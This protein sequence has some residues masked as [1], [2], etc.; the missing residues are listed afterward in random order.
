MELRKQEEIKFHNQREIDR[1]NLTEDAYEKKYSNKKFYSVQRRSTAYM[2]ALLDKYC[3]GKKVLDYC[4]GLG[5][6][7]LELA[8]REAEV[9]GIDISDESVKTTEE[10][11]R[12]SG[13]G[14]NSVFQV[15]D[16]ENMSFPDDMF[17]VIVCTGVLHHLDLKY[18]F[19]ELARVLK[20]DGKIICVE[21]LGYN[22][23]INLYRKLTPH[24][25]T[26]WETDHILTMRQLNNSRANFGHVDVK[27][28]HIFTLA[29]IP[30]RKSVLFEPLLRALEMVDEVILRLP[31]LRLLAWQMVFMLSAPKRSEG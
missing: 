6:T 16:A 1:H 13:Y 10:R 2:H 27:F 5:Q 4:C 22:P 23:I 30:F 18:A 9:Y 19:P 20:P 21:A 31:L 12:N 14:D 24:L 15:M 17:D 28:F 29:A 7:S 11:L 26:A 25:R 8:Q 3:P